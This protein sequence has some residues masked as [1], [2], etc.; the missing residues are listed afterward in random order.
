[1]AIASIAPRAHADAQNANNME[2]V[3]DLEASISSASVPAH[4]EESNCVWAAWDTAK[5]KP[6]IKARSRLASSFL[7][8]LVR[9]RV[10]IAMKTNVKIVMFSI[11]EDIEG[12]N[13][14]I[15]SIAKNDTMK[16]PNLKLGGPSDLEYELSNSREAGEEEATLPSAAPKVAARGRVR[17]L[18]YPSFSI[19]PFAT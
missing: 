12:T 13:I 19:A 9:K 16:I 2:A 15:A 17:I 10:E 11:D 3:A 4:A 5:W 18:R 6:T 8:K 14:G 7:L 1:M